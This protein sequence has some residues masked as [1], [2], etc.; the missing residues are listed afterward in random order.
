MTPTSHDDLQRSL[1]RVE[2]SQASIGARLDRLEDE[3]R[4]GFEEIKAL[5]T[6]KHDDID[7]RVAELEADKAEMRGAMWALGTVITTI[8]GFV[9][10]VVSY[11]KG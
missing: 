9:S 2:G 11:L 7:K 4:K 1:G 10:W 8:A 5:I 6:G 3:M